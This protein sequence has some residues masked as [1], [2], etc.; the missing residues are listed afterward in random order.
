MNEDQEALDKLIRQVQ[1]GGRAAARVDADEVFR[2]A[3]LPD[4]FDTS[5]GFVAQGVYFN[6]DLEL[7]R[8]MLRP[9]GNPEDYLIPQA[10]KFFSRIS[11]KRIRAIFDDDE[12]TEKELIPFRAE[13][14]LALWS[15]WG[16]RDVRVY[17]IMG[18]G[19][20][21]VY[22]VV[23]SGGGGYEYEE[24]FGPVFADLAAVDTWARRLSNFYGWFPYGGGDLA[25]MIASAKKPG[26]FSLKDRVAKRPLPSRRRD[27]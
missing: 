3:G 11:R 15:D 19:G 23:V 25:G 22:G 20:D 16:G 7:D 9:G 6:G 27:G 18:S 4:E 26:A 12:L 2:L 21:V 5:I 17:R 8:S 1:K 13:R 10:P 14:A 24:S